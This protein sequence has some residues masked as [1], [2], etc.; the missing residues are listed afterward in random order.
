MMKVQARFPYTSTK[1]PIAGVDAETFVPKAGIAPENKGR[2]L[3]SLGGGGTAPTSALGA[4]PVA[5]MGR[6]TVISLNP[7]TDKF[8]HASEDIAAVY[9]ELLKDHKPKNIGIYGCSGGGQ[10]TAQAI[11]WFDK[12]KLPMPGAIGIYCAGLYPFGQGD[13]E[14]IWVRLGHGGRSLVPREP[15][16]D[17]AGAP[18]P[19]RYLAGE[20]YMN[21][22]VRPSASKELLKHFPPTLLLSG[23]RSDDMSVTVQTNLDLLDAGVNSR[24][25]LFDGL[26]HGFFSDV[27]LPESQL[28]YKIMVQWFMENL[29]RHSKGR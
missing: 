14:Q 21:P 5:G 17:W 16:K 26:W 11:A 9:R 27:D 23:T 29:G 10:L 3:I 18:T 13:S 19:N 1:A 22:L 6:I 28:A 2:V 4:A 25:V 20:S 7:R 24:L 12:E 8:P 15:I